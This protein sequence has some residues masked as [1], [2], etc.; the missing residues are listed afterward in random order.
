MFLLTS[1]SDGVSSRRGIDS[2]GLPVDF[3]NGRV[4]W[5][6]VGRTCGED[7]D[8]YDAASTPDFTTA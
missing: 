1:N 5:A 3:D 7:V 6:S 2:A 4:G 8:E